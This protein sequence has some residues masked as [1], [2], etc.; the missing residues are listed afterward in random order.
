[1]NLKVSS[2]LAAFKGQPSKAKKSK[3]WKERV[4]GRAPEG[5]RQQRRVSIICENSKISADYW[6]RFQ[7]DQQLGQWEAHCLIFPQDYLASF[8]A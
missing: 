5:L 4:K 3:P 6:R 7:I 8:T 1:M 2:M